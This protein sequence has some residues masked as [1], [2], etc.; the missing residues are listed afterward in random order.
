MRTHCTIELARLWAAVKSPKASAES[1]LAKSFLSILLVRVGNCLWFYLLVL[2]CF[3]QGKLLQRSG[4]RFCHMFMS[5]T[6][7]R[8]VFCLFSLSNSRV[9]GLLL[10]DLSFFFSFG[11]VGVVFFFSPSFHFAENEKGG[12]ERI[13]MLPC[14]LFIYYVYCDQVHNSLLLGTK[15]K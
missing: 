9:P 4:F 1:F 11:S 7:V 2:F 15:L 5:L 10:E 13:L 14:S 12:V 6:I 8:K 3:P